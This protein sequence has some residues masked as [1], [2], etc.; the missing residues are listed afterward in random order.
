VPLDGA[1][2]AD[3]DAIAA[4]RVAWRLAEQYPQIRMAPVDD[5]HRAQTGWAM[6][7]AV[8]RASYF[9]RTP[10]KE[11]LADGVRSAWPLIPAQE[12]TDAR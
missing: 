5:L 2:S 10:G 3:A 11:H 8:S 6:E 12:V 4:C 1:H 9:A 7:Q